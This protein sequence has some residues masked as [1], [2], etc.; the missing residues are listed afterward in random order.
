MPKQPVQEIKLKAKSESNRSHSP[1]SS[2]GP[3][4]R[5]LQ[6]ENLLL[7]QFRKKLER[8]ASDLMALW[9]PVSISLLTASVM[10]MIRQA[11]Q[12]D[13]SAEDHWENVRHNLHSSRGELP[14]LEPEIELN[15]ERLIAASNSGGISKVHLVLIT[16]VVAVVVIVVMSFLMVLLLKLSCFRCLKIYI[17]VTFVILGAHFVLFWFYTASNATMLPVDWITAIVC[18]YN[19]LAIVALSM[20]M[21]QSAPKRLVQAVH[22]VLAATV[23]YIISNLLLGGSFV[24]ASL[25]CVAFS[26]WDLFAVLCP[27]GP[28]NSLIKM[29][30]AETRVTDF[31]QPLVYTAA[32]W[33]TVTAVTAK[34]KEK[35]RRGSRLGL[36][37]FIF[38]GVLVA[39]AT[40]QCGPVGGLACYAALLLGFCLTL[41]GLRCLGRALPALPLPVAAAVATVCL[42]NGCGIAYFEALAERQLMV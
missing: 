28:L 25:L 9:T 34:P 6:Q 41:A 19:F 18:A 17:S 7:L 42:L 21:G 22:V 3:N 10:T 31:M 15:A 16:C 39:T 40:V 14:F 23:S 30:E 13:T 24:Y 26:L 27:R 2:I 1:S 29:A 11:G 36:G 4:N 8:S 37:D 5:K 32:V 38:Y 20:A 35:I 12:R 33:T